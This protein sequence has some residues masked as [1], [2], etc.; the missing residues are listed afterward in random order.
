MTTTTFPLTL[1]AI[2]ENFPGPNNA[3][4]R[5]ILRDAVRAGEGVPS[6]SSVG[7]TVFGKASLEAVRAAYA[8]EV[9]QESK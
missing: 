4:V 1:K 6:L 7:L 5:K 8:G 9:S 3:G 2:A